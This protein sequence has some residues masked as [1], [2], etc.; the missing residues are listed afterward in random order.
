MPRTRRYLTA[1]VI[2]AMASSSLVGEALASN[3]PV[4]FGD[5]PDDSAHFVTNYTSPGYAHDGIAY[6]ITEL[7][8]SSLYL[9]N[10]SSW[11]DVLSY[12]MDIGP[13]AGLYQ[14]QVHLG[15]PG[16]YC[17]TSI[18][19]FDDSIS[20]DT[21]NSLYWKALACHELGHSGG[22]GERT[23]AGTSSCL[24]NPATS[25]ELSLN[26]DDVATLNWIRSNY[27]NP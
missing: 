19:W 4:D 1:A 27:P 26:S 9:Y 15:S 25:S 13:D 21:A 3:P 12:I 23:V 11:L 24:I 6:G 22:V 8:R 5:F 7:D 2:T 10:S 17:D 20:Q 14:C 16:W 18:T